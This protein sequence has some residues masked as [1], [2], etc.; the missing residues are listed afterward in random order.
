MKPTTLILT[1]AAAAVV[2]AQNAL[3]E[4][5]D[6]KVRDMLFA[7]FAGD[8]EKF[9]KGMQILEA[10]LAESPNHPEALVWHG[11]GL[12]FRSGAH[13]RQGD[14]QKGMELYG[15][16]V[17]EMDRAVE[18]APDNVGVR[19]PRAATL[20][21]AASQMRGNPMAKQ[22]IEKAISDYEKTLALQVAIF[23][24]LG[25]HPRGELLQGLA[26]AYRLTG[27]DAKAKE[28]YARLER[29]LPGTPYAQRAAKFRE[30]GT[31]SVAET[32]CIG[33]HVK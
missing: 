22:L 27:Q 11:S 15:R 21:A 25:T 3:P 26:N 9:E 30:T 33:C 7:G 24:K 32:M 23:D 20:L 17:G 16:G 8:A 5:Y 13:F 31:L 19:V 10:T 6:H 18:L 28:F 2:L 14:M 4:R 29:D 12:F 1:L